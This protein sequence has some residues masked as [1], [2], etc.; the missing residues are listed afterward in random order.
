MVESSRAVAER[1]GLESDFFHSQSMHA[2]GLNEAPSVAGV[3][4]C[5]PRCLDKRTEVKRVS[6]IWT[7]R[8]LRR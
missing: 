6:L 5:T 1:F 3:H 2:D 8:R 4:Y 7:S